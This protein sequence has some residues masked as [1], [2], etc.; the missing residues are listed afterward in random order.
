MVMVMVNVDLY[1]A[2][3]QKSLMRS[4]THAIVRLSKSYNQWVH[5][6][7]LGCWGHRSEKVKLKSVDYVVYNMCEYAVLQKNKIII[8]NVFGS[9]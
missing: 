9:Y 3:S 7:Q 4:N 2:S 6:S 8:H 1:S 5:Q